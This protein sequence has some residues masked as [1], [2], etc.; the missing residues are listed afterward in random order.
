V[1]PP[2]ET[3]RLLAFSDG[4]FALSA[5]LLVVTL[6]EVPGSYE[7][8]L[9]AVAR[10]P[11]FALA[12]A[13][14]VSLWWNHRQFFVAY[15]LG[16]GWTVVLNSLLL[17][18]VLLYVYPLK[19]LAEVV[20]ERFLGA[21]PDV[22]AGMGETETRGLFLVFG[23]ALVAVN[24]LL[25]ALHVRAWLLR[26]EL[27]LDELARFELRQEAT[28][29]GA[30]GAVAVLSMLVAAARLGIGWGL[31]L[32]V[33]VGAPVVVV[34]ERLL[35]AEHRRRLAGVRRAGGACP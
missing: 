17:L 35:T 19:L 16:D 15:P 31:P 3:S 24:A 28:V 5:T 7:E 29:Y 9:D 23:A 27:G 22:T 21:T 8:L 13:A 26:R 4:V 11:A 2:R 33:L 6:G 10:F 20:S 14:L 34:A 18:V 32:W 12:F 30:I 1:P 25:G